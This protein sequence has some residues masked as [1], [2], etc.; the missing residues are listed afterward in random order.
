[1]STDFAAASKGFFERR[2]PLL[3]CPWCGIGFLTAGPKPFVTLPSRASMDQSRPDWDPFDIS[4]SFHGD[5][6]CQ[7]PECG[8]SVVMIGDFYLDYDYFDR[9]RELSEYFV[10]RQM[11]P[12]L[13]L[14]SPPDGA[15]SVVGYYIKRAS[16]LFWSDREAAANALRSCIEAILDAHGVSSHV[17]TKSG[18]QRLKSLHERLEEFEKV[19]AEA[20]VL[21]EAVKWIGNQGSHS[22]AVSLTHE[23]ILEDV[24]YLEAGLAEVYPK[25]HSAAIARAQLI[26][27]NRGFTS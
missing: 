15:P 8:E 1:M 17:T 10:I 19:N 20:A 26:N 21:F 7:Y 6:R 25:D 9:E 16:S 14:L 22:S 4:G 13:P 24:Q 12:A 27:K 18:K 5:V 3:Q 11:M 2:L 23:H